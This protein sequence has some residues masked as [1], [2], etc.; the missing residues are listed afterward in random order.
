MNF[1]LNDALSSIIFMAS[2][3]R[4]AQDR[5]YIFA[6][7]FLSGILSVVISSVIFEFSIFS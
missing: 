6:D 7:S 4:E 1:A 3:I 5:T 2:A